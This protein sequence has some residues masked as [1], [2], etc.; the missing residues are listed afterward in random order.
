ML[1]QN[2]VSNHQRIFGLDVMRAS[3]IL[4]VL[5]SHVL[6]LFPESDSFLVD[7][8]KLLGFFGVEMFFVL[9]GFLIGRILYSTFLEAPFTLAV[10]WHFLKRRWY[11]TLPNYYLI[12]LVNILIAAIIGYKVEHLWRYFVFMQNFGWPMLAFFP[13][14]WSLSVEETAY[15]S[16]PLFLWVMSQLKARS[17]SATFF[18]TVLFL[19]MGGFFLK[20][21]YHLGH[22][23]NTLE[24]WNMGL[25]AVAIF[26]CDAIIM[27][28]LFSW[29]SINYSQ[30]WFKL[31]AFAA[32]VGL[33]LVF[34]LSFGVGVCNLLIERVPLF[35]NVFYL[36]LAS[37]AFGCFL[38]AL[39]HWSVKENWLTAAVTFIAVISYA[40]YLLHYG[41]VLQLLKY[42]AYSGGL[43]SQVY[44]LVVLYFVLTF[45][46]GY[47]LYRY[48]EKP[49]TDLRDRV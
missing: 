31:Q 41:V 27:G 49:C 25:K 7:L 9:S 12:L 10:V 24:Q 16:L 6:W 26:R 14:S 15:L 36:P 48:Y 40:M 22:Q 8:L 42:F 17:K 21:N 35:W 23:S 18:M 43:L 5:C 37:I 28:V 32:Y 47:L 29:L 45:L 46:L 19:L 39:S 44:V 3:A 4:M 34:L 2:F 1:H 33:L 11:R 13:E 30:L 20:I 38:P